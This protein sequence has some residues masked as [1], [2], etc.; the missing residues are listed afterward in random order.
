MADAFT[1]EYDTYMNAWVDSSLEDGSTSYPVG[2]RDHTLEKIGE[3]LVLIAGIN[4]DEDALEDMW[5]VNY[6]RW[7]GRAV[8]RNIWKLVG[9]SKRAG[10]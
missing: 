8:L 3:F 2:R 10:V 9:V 7:A 6:S 4:N 1:H 5:R